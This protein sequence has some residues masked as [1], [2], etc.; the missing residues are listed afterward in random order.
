[1]FDGN[2]SDTYVIGDI[3]P[4]LANKHVGIGDGN[5]IGA[6]KVSLHKNLGEFFQMTSWPSELG[7]ISLE[8]KAIM[9]TSVE[10]K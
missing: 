9:H 2:E 3:V 7:T 5:R 8:E 1:M 4:L 10:I 6:R